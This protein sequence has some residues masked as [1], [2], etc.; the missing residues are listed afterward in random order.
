MVYRAS[1]QASA[2][3]SN[4]REGAHALRESLEKRAGVGEAREEGGFL[5]GARER[6]TV[7][8]R[9]RS[10]RGDARGLF[11]HEVGGH[12]L[13]GRVEDVHVPRIDADAHR[14]LIEEGRGHGVVGAVDGD[15]AVLLDG[16]SFLAGRGNVDRGKRDETGQLLGEGLVD[17]A[18]GGAVHADVGHGVQPLPALVIRVGV[19]RL[20]DLCLQC[21][22][23][24]V[25][26]VVGRPRIVLEL[27]LNIDR[28]MGRVKCWNA[29]ARQ[30]AN[31]G[32]LPALSGDLRVIQQD[33]E[34][35]YGLSC[36]H[37]GDDRGREAD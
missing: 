19:G 18:A 5:D 10:R 2:A 33:W 35:V 15:V 23:G 21:S 1:C 7:R 34:I 29:V 9:R 24:Q 30:S 28:S 4:G 26:V 8:T 32:A 13:T 16:A 14:A 12:D 37:G 11:R 36:A 17:T 20:L 27:C 31:P 6:R 22:Q 25:I 3:T